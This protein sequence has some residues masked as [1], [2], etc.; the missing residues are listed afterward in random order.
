MK[1]KPWQEPLSDLAYELESKADKKDFFGIRESLDARLAE[2]EQEHGQV[3]SGM[4]AC[5]SVL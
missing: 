3:F 4:E 5:R 1:E 2:F